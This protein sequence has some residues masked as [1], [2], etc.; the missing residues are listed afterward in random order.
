MSSDTSVQTNFHRKAILYNTKEYTLEKNITTV[1]S[2]QNNFQRT[3]IIQDIKDYT[4][5]KSLSF[6]CYIRPK[7]LSHKCNLSQHQR[8]HTGEKPFQCNICSKRLSSKRSLI[9][10]R[11]ALAVYVT[12]AQKDFL[13]REFFSNI[14]CTV[15]T[16]GKLFFWYSICPKLLSD[17]ESNHQRVRTVDT[18]F[19]GNVCLK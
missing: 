6:Q 11:K 18:P 14:K 1:T 8:I 10:L 7:Q 12:S 17:R 9:Q 4:L 19:Q 2:A 16:L 15:H 13:T 3:A 5:E